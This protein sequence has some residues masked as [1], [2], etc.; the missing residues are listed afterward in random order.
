MLEPAEPVRGAAP[1]KVPE[2][3]EYTAPLRGPP[4]PP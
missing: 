4:D 2:G 3:G 1:L